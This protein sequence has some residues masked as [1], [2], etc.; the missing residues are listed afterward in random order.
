VTR[1]RERL[2]VR[3]IEEEALVAVMRPEVMDDG[4]RGEELTRRALGTPTPRLRG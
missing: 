1:L 3:F 4:R 2:Q